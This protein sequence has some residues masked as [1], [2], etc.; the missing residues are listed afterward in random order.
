M[1]NNKP[2]STKAYLNYF[3]EDLRK[4]QKP[5]YLKRI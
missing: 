1:S 3:I 5:G 4:F 2:Q